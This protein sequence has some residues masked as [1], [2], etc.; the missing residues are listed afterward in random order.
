MQGKHDWVH[1]DPRGT[2]N[3]YHYQMYTLWIHEFMVHDEDINDKFLS[4]L[5]QVRRV[6]VKIAVC[7]RLAQSCCG[8]LVKASIKQVLGESNPDFYDPPSVRYLLS[9]VVNISPSVD[10]CP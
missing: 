6:G 2:E 8:V 3:M 4:Y 9:G 7:Q 10:T 1:Y 5:L